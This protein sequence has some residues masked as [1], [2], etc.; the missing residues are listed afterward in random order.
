MKIIQIHIDD[1][2]Y[3]KAKLLRAKWKDVFINGL[4]ATCKKEIDSKLS[5]IEKIKELIV[6]A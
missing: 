5:E 3:N 2:T 4:E 6:D 1:D